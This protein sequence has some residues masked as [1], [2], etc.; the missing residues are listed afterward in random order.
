MELRIQRLLTRRVFIYYLTTF[1]ILAVGEVTGYFMSLRGIQ[2]LSKSELQELESLAQHPSYMVIFTHNLSLN[3]IMNIPFIGPIMY[4]IL[5]GFTGI[6]LGY[7]VVSSIGVSVLYLILAYVSSAI[8]P[9]G[10]LELFSYSLSA[11]NSVDASVNVIKRR[12][13]NTTLINWVLRLLL[14][15]LILFIAA[16]VE[17]LEL[18]IM[19]AVIHA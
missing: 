5:I 11:Y 15:V 13:L 3:L 9:H 4:V 8:L 17:Y 19:G 14:S 16:Y 2:V 12:P 7:I 6:A 1:L 10:L 18:T